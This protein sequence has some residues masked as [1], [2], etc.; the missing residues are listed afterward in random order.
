MNK[1]SKHFFGDVTL[2]LISISFA[3][4]IT[5]TGVVREFIEYFNDLEWVGILLAGLFFTSAF[6]T[7]PA[8]A[9]LGTLTETNPLLSLV[10]LGGIGATLGDYIIFRFI[11]DRI[12]SDV[13]YLLSFSKRLRFFAIFKTRLFKFFVPF[14]GALIIASPF[15]DEIGI[16]MIGL[17]KINKKIF[18]LIS[19]LL[20]GIGIF[21]IGWLA[22]TIV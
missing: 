17:S 8:I 6:T 11:K 13:D 1:K 3:I 19:F 9:V 7:A 15:P 5:K 16:T 21:I 12:S 10:I 14:I 4:F 22:K 20:N 2:L 18:L